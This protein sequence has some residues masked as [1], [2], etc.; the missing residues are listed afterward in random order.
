MVVSASGKYSPLLITAQ[1]GALLA[2][3]EIN[4]SGE[5]TVNLIVEDD[6][7]GEAALEK[8]KSLVD[9][10][11]KYIVFSI[12]SGSYADIEEYITR[13]D[14]LAIS[15]TVS[16]DLFTGK[17][18][19]FIRFSA[20]ISGFAA[21]LAEYA[22][23]RGVER[24]AVV[25]DTNNRQY[26][27]PLLTQFRETL[28]SLSSGPEIGLI[29]FNSTENPSFVRLGERIAE[30]QPEGVLVIASPFDAAML[31]QHFLTTDYLVLLAPWAISNE[32]IENGGRSVEDTVFF[33][34]NRYPLE[35][36]HNRE[37]VATYT[38]RFGSE[39]TYQAMSNYDT[40]RFLY[41][42]VSAEKSIN[43]G[44]VKQAFIERR[45]F[46]GI[47]SKYLLD[48]FGDCTFQLYPYTVKDGRF[49]PLEP[50]DN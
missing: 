2:A 4:E 29:E 34:R 48:K 25:Y 38:E 15:P 46:S 43:P 42:I 36:E 5:A 16:S 14:I 6:E 47:N 41:E 3:E 20:N 32:L 28:D 37:F 8:T 23:N 50:A 13:Q 26:A 17:D 45:E 35:H 24:V 27:E 39:P 19:N 22:A 12:T 11:L 33:L 44:E 1:N 49:T 7:S 21:R 30:Q 9:R 18:D 10:G 40:M 31:C